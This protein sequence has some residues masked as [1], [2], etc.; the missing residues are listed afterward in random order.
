MSDIELDDIFRGRCFVIA[1]LFEELGNI[2]RKYYK[3]DYS[4]YFNSPGLSWDAMLKM[5]GVKL[6]L[7][8]DIDRYL[9]VEKSMKGGLSYIAQRYSKV[10]NKYMKLYDKSN[11][12]KYIID[13]DANNLH[14]WRLSHYVP[15]GK[16]K[17]LALKKLTFSR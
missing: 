8:S 5:T 15:I 7:I 10:N 16:F 4:H 17:W 9:F 12:S 3:L 13:L 14:G 2:Y 1:D 11:P 6:D